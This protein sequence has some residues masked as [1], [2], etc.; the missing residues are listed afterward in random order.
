MFQNSYMH[1]DEEFQKYLENF[2]ES[3]KHNEYQKFI[4]KENFLYV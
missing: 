2:N 4:L 1:M 3:V